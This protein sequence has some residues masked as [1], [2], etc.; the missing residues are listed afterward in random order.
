MSRMCSLL[1]IG[2]ILFPIIIANVTADGSD[3][4]SKILTSGQYGKGYRY[5]IQG[6]VYIHIEGEPYERGFQ[7]GYLASNEIKD[8][9]QRWIDFEYDRIKISKLIK[10]RNSEKLWDFFRLKAKNSFLKYIP[11]E[12]IEELRGLTDGLNARG[13]KIFNRNIEFNDILAFQFIQDIEYRWF[14][15]PRKVF[16]PIRKLYSNIIQAISN[17]KDATHVGH[18]TAFI[19]TGDAT[20]NG[21]IVVAHSSI[22]LTIFLNDVI[23]Y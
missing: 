22:F 8:I 13:V 9:F 2:I 5:N 18:C 6:W 21:E 12:Y 20:K 10:Y 14:K 23:L 19:A 3:N 11:N 4:S 7:Y 15:Y 16:Q 1:V 17:T